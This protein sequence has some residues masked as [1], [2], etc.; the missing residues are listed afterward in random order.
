V[1]T[2]LVVAGAY[3][4]GAIPWSYLIVRRVSGEDVRTLGSGNVGATNVLRTTGRAA[5]AVALALDLGKGVA[6]VAIARAAEL[7]AAAVS[8]AAVAAVVGHSFPVFIGFR[9]GKGVATGA[10]ALLVLAPWAFAVVVP[11]FAVLVRATGYVAVGS[12]AAAALAPLAVYL[13]GR[14]GLTRPAEPAL[15]LGVG[16]IAALIAGRHHGNLRRLV[17]GSEAKLSDPLEPRGPARPGG[18]P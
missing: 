1:T 15:L 13:E 4:L 2:W 8:G 5:G 14:W 7:P 17:A 3:L 16:A 11:V 9:G 10:G 6:A 18:E 12:V